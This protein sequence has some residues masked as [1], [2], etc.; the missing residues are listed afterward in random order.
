MGPRPGAGGLDELALA[1]VLAALARAEQ[2]K[3]ILCRAR[4]AALEDDVTGIAL[5]GL[6]GLPH[7]HD[8]IDAEREGESLTVER[9]LDGGRTERLR[10]RTPAL[11]AIRTG[12]HVPR[13]PEPARGRT[14]ARRCDRAARAGGSGST[15]GRSRGRGRRVVALRERPAR[16]DTRPIEGSP[17]EIAAASPRS[18]GADRIVS[19]VIVLGELRRGELRPVGQ[20]PI[21]A[22]LPRSPS[23]AR[24]P[25]CSRRS[26]PRPSPRTPR[27]PRCRH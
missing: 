24:A 23:R 3:L 7:A 20:E 8:V 13:Q 5:A 27:R 10:L 14:R 16:V 1:A 21:G 4:S 2:P 26:T 11:L 17:A 22:A 12:H 15:R 9:R 25:W 19:E 18:P 6:L